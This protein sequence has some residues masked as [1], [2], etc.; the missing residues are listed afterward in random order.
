[1]AGPALAASSPYKT[2]F[3][4]STELAYIMEE[5]VPADTPSDVE[6]PGVIEAIG[7][8]FKGIGTG[9]LLAG[10]AVTGAGSAIKVPQARGGFFSGIVG[11][12]TS[13]YSEYEAMVAAK[14]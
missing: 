7:D 11:H 8:W 3:G 13:E 6:Q 4:N 10:A 14:R 5:R 9:T 1:M 2:A 12:D